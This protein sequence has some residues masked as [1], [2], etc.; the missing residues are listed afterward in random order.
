MYP[1][2]QHSSLSISSPT[3][4]RKMEKAAAEESLFKKYLR[5]FAVVTAYW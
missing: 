5:I 2:Q 1:R 4:K 3:L